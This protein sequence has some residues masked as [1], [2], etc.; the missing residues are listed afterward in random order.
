MIETL[1][2]PDYDRADKPTEVLK[3]G[4]RKKKSKKKKPVIGALFFLVYD[5]EERILRLKYP[6]GKKMVND[7]YFKVEMRLR[8]LDV[9]TSSTTICLNSGVDVTLTYN[10]RSWNELKRRAVTLLK[11]RLVEEGSDVERK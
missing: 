3:K 7:D 6:E 5:S 2:I 10:K 1:M 11:A 4:R 8:L 9:F